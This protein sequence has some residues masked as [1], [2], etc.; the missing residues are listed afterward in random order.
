[1][2]SSATLTSSLSSLSILH[3]HSH[4]HTSSRFSLL[5][6]PNPKF[7]FSILTQQPQSSLPLLTTT[8]KAK[9]SDEIDTSFFDNVN[10]EEN[11]PFNPPEVPEDFVA[12]PSIDEGPLETEDEIAAA[13]EELYG[14][15]YSGVSVLGNDIYVMDAKVR[16]ETG[17]G[18][19]SK[20]EKTRD[21]FEERVVQVRR[22]TKVVK[23]GKQMRFRAVVVVGDKNGQVG[24]GVGKAKEV[25]GAVQKSAV[26][27]RRNIIKV[28]LT[29]YST[30]PHRADGDYGAAKVML[31]PASPGTGVIAGGAVRI[32]L[33]MAGVENA[34]GKQLGSNNAL[35]NARATV[36]AVQK[37]KQ[38]R[39]VAQERGIPMEELWK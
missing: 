23:G 38:F 1:M 22:V 5:H 2:A 15:A 11:I 21:G 31:R 20:R 24:V 4:S 16:K 33:E 9:S 30:F 19:K 14:P 35:N 13:Y 10:P 34:L 26:N 28:P 17:F 39:E 8:K 37:M 3:S 25:V 32:V 29:K 36:V 18:S 6:A 12:P 27:A 7:T